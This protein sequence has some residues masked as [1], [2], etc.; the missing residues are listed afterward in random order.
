MRELSVSTT[1]QSVGRERDAGMYRASTHSRSRVGGH[2]DWR[3][4]LPV[5]VGRGMQACTKQVPTP[6][7]RRGVT[8]IRGA[9]YLVVIVLA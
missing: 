3:C 8:L 1:Q 4:H 9:T 7:A 2:F 6:G 5:G